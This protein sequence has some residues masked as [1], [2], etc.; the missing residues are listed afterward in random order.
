MNILKIIATS[1]IFL[2]ALCVSLAADVYAPKP[3]QTILEDA[4]LRSNAL[5]TSFIRYL[6]STIVAFIAASI[7]YI[8][9]IHNIILICQLSQLQSGI[10]RYGH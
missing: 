5:R 8:V 9:T 7:M 1:I 3:F 6:R 2:A 10:G 4:S